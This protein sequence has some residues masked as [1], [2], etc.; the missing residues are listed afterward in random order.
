MMAYTGQTTKMELGHVI[1]SITRILPL[2]DRQRSSLLGSAR[3]LLT[4]WKVCRASVSVAH[5]PLVSEFNNA[6]IINTVFAPLPSYLWLER[7]EVPSRH[8]TQKML[9]G[10][11]ELLTRSG[12]TP[13]WRRSRCSVCFRLALAL[14]LRCHLQTRRMRIMRMYLCC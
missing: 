3:A 6:I 11:I 5:K 1:E 9:S 2:R 14:V 12:D 8:H 13:Y 10:M 4:Y 7:R